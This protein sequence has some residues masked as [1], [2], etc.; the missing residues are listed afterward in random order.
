MDKKSEIKYFSVTEIS[1]IINLNCG[2]VSL[3]GNF[4]L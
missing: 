1:E 3:W 4:Q 2:D